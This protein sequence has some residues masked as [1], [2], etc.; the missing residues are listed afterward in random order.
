MVSE[1]VGKLSKVVYA[2]ESNLY[3]RFL[4]YDLSM[5]LEKVTTLP[6]E[7]DFSFIRDVYDV[8]PKVDTDGPG[9]SIM[10]E[11]FGYEGK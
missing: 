5:V 3:P 6:T 11:H 4:S 9:I 8:L 2:N 7:F 1:L 10:I